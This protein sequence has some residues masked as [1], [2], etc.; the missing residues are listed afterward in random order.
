[1][2]QV[3]DTSDYQPVDFGFSTADADDV[4]VR[5]VIGHTSVGFS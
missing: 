1:M 3:M 5:F 2:M 4:S